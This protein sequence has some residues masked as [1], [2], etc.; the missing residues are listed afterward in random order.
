MSE[1][2][3][4]HVGIIM[5][6]NR[7][8]AK[9]RGVPTAEGHRQGYKTLKELLKSIKTLNIEYLSVYSF[10]TEN[11]SRSK[12][13]VEGI[14]KLL[15][16]V[17]RNELEELVK[18]GIRVRWVGPEDNVPA[19]VVKAIRRAESK[20]EK[21]TEGT[22]ALCFNYGGQQEIADAAAKVAATG[23]EITPESIEANLYQPDIPPIDLLIRTSGEQRLSNFMLWRSAYAEF[24]F[25]PTLW[26][27]FTGQELEQMVKDYNN[28]TRRF[29]G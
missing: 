26:P 21:L 15:M 2:A 18:E 6:G 5:D 8:W 19:D 10:S 20:T 9:K 22:L 4:K 16:W 27:D 11:W 28:R 29:G 23:D 17:I 25:T 1:T 7:R 14:M 24:A 12:E 3:I 13:E